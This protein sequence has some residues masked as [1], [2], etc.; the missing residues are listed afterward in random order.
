MALTDK[1]T[2]D[3]GRLTFYR[4]RLEAF[5]KL[6]KEFLEKGGDIS[7]YETRQVLSGLP[8]ESLLDWKRTREKT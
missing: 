2:E 4:L 1:N 7:E 5:D 6:W 8:I 3:N